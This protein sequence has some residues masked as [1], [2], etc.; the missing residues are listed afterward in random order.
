MEVMG[1]GRQ[2]VWCRSPRCLGS[3]GVTRGVFLEVTLE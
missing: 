2:C 3:V 1:A